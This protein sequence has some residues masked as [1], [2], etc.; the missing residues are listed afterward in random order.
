[1]VWW[2]AGGVAAVL[3]A[4]GVIDAV[5]R[6]GEAAPTWQS[7]QTELTDHGLSD[8]EAQ[9]VVKRLQADDGPVP[10]LD[11]EGSAALFLGA[12][13][14]CEGLMSASQANCVFQQSGLLRGD[15]TD[16]LRELAK[17]ASSLD[18][19]GREAV[20]EASLRCQGASEAVAACVT[21]A[22]RREFGKDI[23]DATRLELSPDDQERL[24]TLTA[25]CVQTTA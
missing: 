18:A 17:A 12:I 15:G 2:I 23:F 7:V 21:D 1:M 20:A 6:V 24:A 14:E 4:L 10:D 22:V 3:I 13:L 19:A 25:E 11:K 16:T 8:D 5:V 9:C